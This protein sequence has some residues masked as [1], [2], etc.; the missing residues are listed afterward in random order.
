MAYLYKRPNSPFWWIGFAKAS[1]RTPESTKLRWDNPSQSRLAHDLLSQTCSEEQLIG[2]D[3]M[4]WAQWVPQLIAERYGSHPANFKSYSNRWRALFT[5]LVERQIEFPNNLTAE[6]C[7]GYI[8]WRTNDQ[9][10]AGVRKACKNTALEEL[11]FLRMLMRHAVAVGY[12]SRD[13][14]ASLRFKWEDQKEKPEIAPE[15]LPL[16]LEALEK[17]PQWMRTQ[18]AIGF[19]TGC[20]ISETN[21]PLRCVDLQRKLLHFPT[22]KGDRPFTVPLPPALVPLFTELINATTDLNARA[23]TQEGS[24]GGMSTAWCAFFSKLGMP[25]SFHC[26]RVSFITRC[27]RAGVPEAVVMRLVNHASEEVHRLYQR[28]NSA[29]LT[30][31]MDR[32]AKDAVNV[33]SLTRAA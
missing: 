3:R 9:P 1:N 28:F 26:L 30:E 23:F 8:A 17:S 16:I 14:M 5:F 11:K 13:P 31:W 32:V 4:K 15:H 33:V 7:Y 19:H 27:I 6:A 20:R 24:A 29:D 12:A 25:Y 22:A 21:V 18:F 2:V 10:R